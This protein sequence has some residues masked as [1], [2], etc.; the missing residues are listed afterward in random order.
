MRA[1]PVEIGIFVIVVEH[2]VAPV[3]G[4]LAREQRLERLALNA[5]ERLDSGIAEEGGGI[6]DILDELVDPRAGFDMTGILDEERCLERFLVHEAL[7]E[8]A[9]LAE[10]EALVRSI[11]DDRILAQP[12]L[13]Q[14]IEQ[15]ADAFVDRGDGRQILL[16]VT[17]I[18]PQRHFARGFF[19][20][21]H[22]VVERLHRAVPRGALFGRHPA[23]GVGPAII[24]QFRRSDFPSHFQV[25]A[26]VHVAG[27]AHRR[28]VRRLAACIIVEIGDR[29]RKG[30]I[31]IFGQ[32]P[33]GGHPVAVRRLVMD[34]QR[35]GLA[36]LALGPQPVEPHIGDEIGRIAG[37]AHLALGREEVGV[38]IFAL[39]IEHLPVIELHPLGVAAQ[40]PFADDRGLVARALQL[41][42]PAV[43]GVHEFLAVAVEPVL[44]PELARQHRRPA[45]P[46]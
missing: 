25:V 39:V 6:V 44:V 3:G 9:M 24:A 8:P 20:S 36:V 18:F 15:L 27:D 1:H 35:K 30:D 21:V 23:K 10:I 45:W 41:A 40:M 5:V 34:H 32:M 17:L 29:H 26:F 38:I 4:V 31:G 11:D 22:P 28:C 13:L 42:R 16:Q 7:V 14:I 19:G 46:A 12:A 43:L 37:H 2:R 33:L